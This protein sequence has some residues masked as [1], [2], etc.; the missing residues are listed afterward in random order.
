MSTHP[1]QLLNS[2]SGSR[3]HVSQA[4]S[5]ARMVETM[6][7]DELRRGDF[8]QVQSRVGRIEELVNEHLLETEQE[9]SL[10]LLAAELLEGAGETRKAYQLTGRLLADEERLGHEF[11]S[12]LRRFRARLAL[13]AGDVASAR[14][15]VSLTDRVVMETLRV[16]SEVEQTVD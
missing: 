5:S 14:S 13:N 12:A 7:K 3:F 16:F 2:S 1:S 11:L 8:L 6:V 15:E 9:R 4:I 10:L